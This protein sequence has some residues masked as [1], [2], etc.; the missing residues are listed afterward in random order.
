MLEPILESNVHLI[1]TNQTGVITFVLQKYARKEHVRYAYMFQVYAHV[2]V[3]TRALLR[4]D[5]LPVD[6]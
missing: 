6:C 5:S 4:A 2:M 3:N 1:F